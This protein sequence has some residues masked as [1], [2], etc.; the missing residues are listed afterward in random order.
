VWNDPEKNI[1]VPPQTRQVGFLFQ[2]YAL[3]PHMTVAENIT[4]AAT[5]RA[6]CQ[7]LMRLMDLTSLQDI[8]PDKLSGGQKQR[9]ALARA[10]AIKPRLL[11]LDEPLS[12]LDEDLRKQLQNEILII[13]RSLFPSIFFVSHDRKEIKK[14][15]THQLHIQAGTATF[16]P[17]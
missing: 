11:L 13:H 12:A 4:Y 14:L 8:H 16:K 1:L 5:D 15:A 6:Y 3:F 7:R 17:L 9:V 10:L 2:D